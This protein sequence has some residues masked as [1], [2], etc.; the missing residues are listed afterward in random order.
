MTPPLPISITGLNTKLSQ[1]QISQVVGPINPTMHESFFPQMMLLKP[2]LPLK[3]SFV[4]NE[5]SSKLN[6]MLENLPIC[7]S[8]SLSRAHKYTS[9]HFVPNLLLFLNSTLQMQLL[10]LRRQ[11]RTCLLNHHENFS[12][13]LSWLSQS[14][15]SLYLENIGALSSSL[16]P[17]PF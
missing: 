14:C 12:L 17:L 3:K 4:L 15:D 16:C 10:V 2:K 13:E 6:R 9:L 11:A 7:V 1:L 5:D 8:P